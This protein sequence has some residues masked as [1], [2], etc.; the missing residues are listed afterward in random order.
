M[1]ECESHGDCKVGDIFLLSKLKKLKVR[2][3]CRF[4]RPEHVA[5]ISGTRTQDS[6]FRLRAV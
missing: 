5:G 4:P 1:H 2:R 6:D 3:L